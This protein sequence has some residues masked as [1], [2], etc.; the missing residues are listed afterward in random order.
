[1]LRAG[2]ASR[3]LSPII[4][5]TRGMAPA[6]RTRTCSLLAALLAWVGVADA[7]YGFLTRMN[8]EL[9]AQ[10]LLT[11]LTA[12]LGHGTSHERLAQHEDVLKPMY[13]A[14]PKQK[15]G[16]IDQGMVCYALNHYFLVHC[17]WHISGIAYDGQRWNGSSPTPLLKSKMS[18]SIIEM[19]Y[20]HVAHKC[21]GL[22]ELAV[23]AATV[24]D[25]MHSDVCMWME[26]LFTTG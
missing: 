12:L 19:L 5:K 8:R 22:G 23:L 14:L 13:M 1:M 10:Q 15:D 24:E 18:S 26:R 21:L 9:L 17:G 3:A 25:L 11:E 2:K 16:C 7:S 20:D 4:P 6:F